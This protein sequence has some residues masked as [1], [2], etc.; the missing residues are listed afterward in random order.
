MRQLTLTAAEYDGLVYPTIGQGNGAQTDGEWETAMRLM[1]VLKEPG[2]TT[3]IP[4]T[5]EQVGDAANGK[6]HVAS[7]R[8]VEDQAVFVLEE[9]C[10]TMLEKRMRAA[11]PGV[12]FAIAD[13]FEALLVKI[14]SAPELPKPTVEAQA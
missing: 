7:R 11:R 5:E 10:V 8:L 1:K 14:K 4:L 6:H 2:I 9:D 13:Q 3:E 12:P